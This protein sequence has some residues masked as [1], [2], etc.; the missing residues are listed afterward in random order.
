[1]VINKGERWKE[2]NQDDANP[3]GIKSREPTVKGINTFKS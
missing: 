3:Q 2:A 1:M